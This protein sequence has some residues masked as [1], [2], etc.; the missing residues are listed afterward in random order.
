MAGAAMSSAL[1]AATADMKKTAS[2]KD[3]KM[4]AMT[5]LCLDECDPR[6]LQNPSVTRDKSKLLD[7]RLSEQDAVEWVPVQE[8]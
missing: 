6:I 3:L 2:T 5:F 8:R 4:R 1:C 7:L